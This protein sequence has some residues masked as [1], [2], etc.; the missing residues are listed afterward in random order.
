MYE[1][2]NYFILVKRE[3]SRIKNIKKWGKIVTIDKK[4]G[5]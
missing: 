5:I 3:K 2:K 4:K 1:V